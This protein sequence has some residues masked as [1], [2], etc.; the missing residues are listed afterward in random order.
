MENSKRMDSDVVARDYR[1][2]ESEVELLVYSQ[3][4]TS[5]IFRENWMAEKVGVRLHQTEHTLDVV[6]IWFAVSSRVAVQDYTVSS[7]PLFCLST[8][9]MCPRVRVV[10]QKPK[11][12]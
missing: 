8:A 2:D 7:N 1:T 11:M 3:K 4:R 12:L 6:V 10:I 5:Q 9:H